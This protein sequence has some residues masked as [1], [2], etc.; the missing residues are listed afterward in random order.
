M[1][2]WKKITGGRISPELLGVVV[3]L[4]D[5]AMSDPLHRFFGRAIKIYQSGKDAAETVWEVYNPDYGNGEEGEYIHLHPCS[6]SHYRIAEAV[7]L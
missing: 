5:D 7:A 1:S 6:F 3:E 2:E 4:Y